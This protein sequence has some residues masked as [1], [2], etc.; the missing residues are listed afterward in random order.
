[1]LSKAGE[2]GNYLL[3]K[4]LDFWL[5]SCRSLHLC[6]Y[7]YPSD[8]EASMSQVTFPAERPLS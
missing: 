7:D 1:M 8:F 4:L 2:Q 6:D 5:E 3:E